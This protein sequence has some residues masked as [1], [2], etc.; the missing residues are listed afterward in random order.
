[1]LNIKITFPVSLPINFPC[2]VFCLKAYADFFIQEKIKN[3]NAYKVF[4][5]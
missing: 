5:K 3:H 4:Y 1:M 2:S